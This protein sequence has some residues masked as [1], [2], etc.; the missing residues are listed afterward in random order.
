MQIVKFH[1]AHLL[2]GG[3]YLECSCGYMPK[4]EEDLYNSL[5]RS[6]PDVCDIVEELDKDVDVEPPPTESVVPP[7]K[8]KKGKKGKKDTK[9]APQASSQ[10]TTRSYTRATSKC[11]SV[12][13]TSAIG[14]PSTAPFIA[15]PVPIFVAPTPPPLIA[16]LL[17]PSSAPSVAPSPTPSDAPS[18]QPPSEQLLI[19][20]ESNVT[21]P[22]LPRKRRASI[23]DTSATSTENSTTLSLI[24]NMDV[25]EVLEVRQKTETLYLAYNRIQAF[26]AKVCIHFPFLLYSFIFLVLIF[27]KF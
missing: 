4:E 1:V 24:E 15:P 21:V 22:S 26:L 13:D 11:T 16:P 17:E 23:F 5:V 20:C 10:V 9:D 8:G 19:P 25:V 2:A 7:V 14:S 6:A 18:K 3:W 27:F 12:L